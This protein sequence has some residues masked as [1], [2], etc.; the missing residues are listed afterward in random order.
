MEELEAY[1]EL[2]E[3]ETGFEASFDI[4]WQYDRLIGLPQPGSYEKIWKSDHLIPPTLKSALMRAAEPLESVPDSEKDWH[5]GSND[6][7]L[8]LVHPSLYPIVYSRS[9]LT[10][11]STVDPPDVTDEFTSKRFQ[12]MPSNFK[13]DIDGTARLVSPYINNLHPQDH[14]ELVGVIA[15]ILAKAVP[16]F[17]RVLSD[18]AREKPLPTRLDLGGRLFPACVWPDREVSLCLRSM[19]STRITCSLRH[20]G[21]VPSLRNGPNSTRITTPGTRNRRR[22]GQT[23]RNITTAVSIAFRRQ[24]T[25]AARRFK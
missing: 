19:P 15:Q 17:E 24:S 25:C 23:A 5:P 16:L 1:A 11:G 18:L 9:I 7:V 3:D 13:V 12:W 4:M 2:R 21:R 14:A 10:S 22:Y 6:Q 20:S 8:N